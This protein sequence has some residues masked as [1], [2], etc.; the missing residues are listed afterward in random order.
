MGQR[1]VRRFPHI[2]RNGAG[3]KIYENEVSFENEPGQKF[4]RL[5]AREIE[6]I[7]KR[8][9]EAIERGQS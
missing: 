4:D 1:R 7:I 2:V 5:T 8:N 6:G 9:L 3:R